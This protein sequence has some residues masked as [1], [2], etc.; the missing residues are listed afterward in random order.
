MCRI[1]AISHVGDLNL[2][3]FDLSNQGF[4]CGVLLLHRPGYADRG[5]RMGAA[6]LLWLPW[7][8]WLLWLLW[9]RR[10]GIRIGYRSCC[11]RC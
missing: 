8:L 9:R 6:V 3:L 11:C 10:L 1:H 5:R 4:Q 7:L 2:K